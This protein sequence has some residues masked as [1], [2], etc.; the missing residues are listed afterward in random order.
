MD[1]K[2]KL[3]EYNIEIN[4]EQIE[5]FD[6]YMKL[7]LEWNEKINLTA[8]TEKDD[9]ILKHFVDSLTILK[10]VDES[11]KIIDI[12]TGAGFPGIPIKIMNEETNITLLD[13]LNKRINFLNIVINELKLDNIVAIHGRA[14]EL[15]RNKAHREKYDVAV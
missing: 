15:A 13:S 4:D 11:D 5:K 14:E 8:I 6:L 10:Y 2:Q 3:E 7:L 9:I 12:G 1:F